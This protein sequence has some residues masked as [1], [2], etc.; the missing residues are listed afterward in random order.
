MMLFIEYQGYIQN[1]NMFYC[2]TPVTICPDQL[3]TD[4]EIL[5]M[6]DKDGDGNRGCN[7]SKANE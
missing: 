1:G 6:Y 2:I 3:V 7:S 4:S 5:G